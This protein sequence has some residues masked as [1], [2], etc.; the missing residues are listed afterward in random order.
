MFLSPLVLGD[1]ES[2]DHIP[3]NLLTKDTIMANNLP[4]FASLEEGKEKY[5]LKNSWLSANHELVLYWERENVL[6]SVKLSYQPSERAFPFL[7]R[8]FTH[9]ELGEFFPKGGADL[10]GKELNE[11]IHALISKAKE[12]I[13]RTLD[14]RKDKGG[15]LVPRIP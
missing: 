10:S 1:A 7:V 11:A 12:P 14:V 6:G 3:L 4:I 15:Y 2:R 5:T 8:A 9:L 13:E